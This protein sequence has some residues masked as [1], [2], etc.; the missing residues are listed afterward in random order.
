MP[1]DSQSHREQDVVA[2]SERNLELGE[3]K[4]QRVELGS[5][6][7]TLHATGR[8]TENINKTARVATMLEGRVLKLNFDINDSVKTGD[9]LGLVETPEL[10]GKS[11]EIKAPI[12]GVVIERSQVVGELVGKGMPIY[13]ISDPTALWVLAEIKEGDLGEVRVG[14]KAVF[15]VLAYP[16]REFS[17]KVVRLGNRLEEVSHTLE[18]R[19]ETRN[20]DGRLKPGMFADIQI[21]TAVFSN[22]PLIPNMAVQWDDDRQ[23]VFVAL[24][25]NKFEKRV[26]RLGREGGRRVQVLSGLK[27]GEWVVT[28]GSFLLKS[29]MLKDEGE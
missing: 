14:Q 6:E 21:T 18:V 24:G 25:N 27:V 12:D 15:R 26:V 2:L 13:T 17:G 16:D 19:I 11:L 1:P 3:V 8:V 20:P 10:L 5:L 29:E 28:E 7:I 22:V 23:I 9:V 4:T